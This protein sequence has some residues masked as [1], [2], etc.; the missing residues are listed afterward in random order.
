MPRRGLPV[1]RARGGRALNAKSERD[2]AYF[3]LLRAREEREGLL[4]YGEYLQAELAR[5]EGFATQTRVLADPL[6]RGLRR[7]VDASA[8]PLLEAVG[9]RRALLLDEQRRMGD[10]VANAERFVDECEAEVDAL[11]R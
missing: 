7:P 8:K 10:R 3:T 11:R 4:R 1:R 9:R 2:A 6:P 5:L